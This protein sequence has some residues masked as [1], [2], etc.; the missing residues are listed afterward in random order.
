MHEE[1]VPENLSENFATFCTALQADIGPASDN[2]QPTESRLEV[3]RKYALKGSQQHTRSAALTTDGLKEELDRLPVNLL[4]NVGSIN[5]AA[6]FLALSGG[7]WQVL[8]VDRDN[9]C[10][11]GQDLE[12]IISKDCSIQ[13]QGL[14]CMF[15]T[16]SKNS[17]C[18]TIK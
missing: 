16:H 1:L 6:A 13:L 11:G 9:G 3:M 7:F 8:G 10:L 18:T 17:F 2:L 15:L 12:G 4:V 14:Q 5:G